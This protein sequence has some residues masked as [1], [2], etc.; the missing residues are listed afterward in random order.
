M[1]LSLLL[2]GRPSFYLAALSCL[3][4]VAFLT[5]RSRRVP[6]GLRR[7]PGPKGLPIVGNTLQ[8][9]PQPQKKLLSWAAEYGEVMQVQIGWE[10]WVYLNSPS[11][12]KEIIDKQSSI[13][14]SRVPM[15]VGN[16]I[17]SGGMRFLLMGY[18]PVWRKLRA[19]VHKLLT[20][21]ASNVFRP[22]QEFETKQ[23]LFDLLTDN[24]DD[25]DFYMHV[26]RYSTSVVLTSTYG[27]R[28]PQWEC[29]NVKEIYGLMKEFSDSTAPGAF[30]ADMIPPLAKLPVFLQWWRPR[31]L[32]YQRRQV[33]IWTKLW[34]DLIVKINNKTAPECFVKQ[35][36]ETDY[37]KQEISEIQGAFMAGTMIEAGSETTSSSL[38]SLILYL[39]ADPVVQACAHAELDRVVGATTPPRFE[40]EDDLPYIRAMI[41][42]ILRIRPVTNMGTPHYTTADVKYK[43]YY[44][45]K[46]TVVAIHTYALHHD[47]RYDD[48]FRFKP[49]R[50]LNHPLKAGAYASHPDPYAR[51]HFDFGGG[52]RICPGMH[53]AENSLFITL[54]NI[55]WAFKIEPGRNADGTVQ[56]VDTSD[57]AFE[58]GAN[59]LPKPFKARFVPRDAQRAEII[60]KQ[61]EKAR[62]EGFFLGDIKVGL[63]G[64]VTSS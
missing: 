22:S 24:K 46:G 50:Y 58:L 29:E 25:Q 21:K 8:L 23:L 47:K 9:G 12:V 39:S 17:I 38:N 15:P 37:K 32:K 11:A 7:P 53:L 26:R 4:A 33:K 36:L 28:A 31:A 30:L 52:R 62:E 42:E 43:D 44:I 61:W 64:V 48:P 63:D 34:D 2:D 19:I 41:K 60:R 1:A 57:D 49:E 27:L 55:L 10:N 3:L 6:R 35:F 16:D 56:V 45:P 40:H 51:D 59:T 5:Y 18:T 54:A 13:T 20:P 14:S